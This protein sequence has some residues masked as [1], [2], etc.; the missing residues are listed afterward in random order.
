MLFFISHSFPFPNHFLFTSGSFLLVTLEC[1]EV[2]DNCTLWC[3]LTEAQGEDTCGHYSDYQVHTMM[4]Q[5]NSMPF[6]K[7]IA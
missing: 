2:Q 4:P 5:V 6:G 7:Q 1:I 3:T